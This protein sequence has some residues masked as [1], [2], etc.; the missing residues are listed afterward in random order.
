MVPPLESVG[1]AP[2]GRAPRARKGSVPM[3]K[4]KKILLMLAKGGASQAEVA[5][6]LRAGRC[7]VS[8]CARAIRERGLT[9]DAVAAMSAAGEG[10]VGE[11]VLGAGHGPAGRAQEAEPQAHGQDVLDGAPRGRRGG[12][13]GSLLVPDLLRDVRRGGGEGGL[14]ISAS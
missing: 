5:A 8:A 6:A 14:T 9:F 13:Q 10:A 3:S 12:R 7:D 1:R 4:K 2:D 11:R